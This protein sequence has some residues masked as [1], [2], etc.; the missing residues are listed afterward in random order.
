MKQLLTMLT[1][2]ACLSA[3]SLTQ[4]AAKD[5]LLTLSEKHR[6]EEKA[7]VESLESWTRNE[8]LYEKVTSLQCFTK[9]ELNKQAC[10]DLFDEVTKNWLVLTDELYEVAPKARALLERQLAE[11]KA[12]KGESR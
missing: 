1:V 12:L 3:A 6:A 11:A 7:L 9:P 4:V 5:D 10:N 8:R 2:S